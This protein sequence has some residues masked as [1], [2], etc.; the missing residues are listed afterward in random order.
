MYRLFRLNFVS[1]FFSF[2]KEN[3][4]SL[5]SVYLKTCWSKV[6]MWAT[7]SRINDWL[8]NSISMWVM[9]NVNTEAKWLSFLIMPVDFLCKRRSDSASYDYL[10]FNGWAEEGVTIADG[11]LHF[12]AK[13]LT[14]K[15]FM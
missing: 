8:N 10:W 6:M 5:N 2:L 12:A 3:C 14:C 13:K 11:F 1:N 15:Y 4:P 9:K 7:H